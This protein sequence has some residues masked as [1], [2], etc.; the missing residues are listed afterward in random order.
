MAEMTP[1]ERSDLRWALA[2]LALAL[3]AVAAM[4]FTTL[5]GRLP[6]G[7]RRAGAGGLDRRPPGDHP[8]LAAPAG[9]AS[10]LRALTH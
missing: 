6:A 2:W 7:A 4:I 10:W 3:V 9:E 5:R 8:R 1:E